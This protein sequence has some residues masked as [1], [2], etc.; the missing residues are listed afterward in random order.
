MNSLQ[1]DN[2]STDQR[3]RIATAKPGE[4]A[5]LSRFLGLVADLLGKGHLHTGARG[6]TPE[7]I[8]GEHRTKKRPKLCFSSPELAVQ[9]DS[10]L[11]YLF[12]YFLSFCLLLGPLPMAYGGS[13]ARG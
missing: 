2:R 6:H 10:I 4:H 3:K 13:Q 12:I 1:H 5:I 8:P 7:G 9:E 11:F